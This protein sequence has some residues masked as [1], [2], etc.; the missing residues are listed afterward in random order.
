MNNASNRVEYPRGEQILAVVADSL[1]RTLSEA[2][3]VGSTIDTDRILS[4][5]TKAIAGRLPVTCM[6]ILLQSD[7]D[8]SRV[9]LADDR[10]PAFIRCV[11]D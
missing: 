1:T 3:A 6:A 5:V 11:E 4:T 2:I 9:H 8:K 7:P 10:N